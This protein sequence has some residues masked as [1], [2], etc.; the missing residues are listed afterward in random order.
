M[1]LVGIILNTTDQL[2]VLAFHVLLAN[3]QTM[4]LV[5]YLKQYA[6][7]AY[8]VNIALPVK[9]KRLPTFVYLVKKDIIVVEKQIVLLV[10]LDHI[11]I[12]L[13]NQVLIH[14]KNAKL[15]NILML[16]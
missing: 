2:K 11:K 3:T 15:G 1:L 13:I 6:F 14:V 10:L 4:A 8:Q 12:Y 5:K 9:P 16:V 7:L